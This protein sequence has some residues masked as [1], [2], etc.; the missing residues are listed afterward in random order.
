MITSV[1]D[2]LKI[3]DGRNALQMRPLALTS[4]WSRRVRCTDDPVRGE[5]TAGKP[6]CHHACAFGAMDVVSELRMPL[7]CLNDAF[8]N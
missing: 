3:V 7:T 4:G 1:R 8:Q 2:V 5:F 6:G